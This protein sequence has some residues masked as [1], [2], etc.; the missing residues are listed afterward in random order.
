M[1]TS[2]S[3]IKAPDDRYSL[4]EEQIKFPT[5]LNEFVARLKMQLGGKMDPF[6][7]GPQL[8][9]P[10]NRSNPGLKW[11]LREQSLLL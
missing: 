11:N 7:R 9:K 10:N 5:N 3:S 4:A 2:E 6:T 1:T 8:Y